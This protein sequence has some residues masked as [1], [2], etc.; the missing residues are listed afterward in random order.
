[1]VVVAVRQIVVVLHANDLASL[2]SIRDLRRRR[3]A[4]SNVTR[5]PLALQIG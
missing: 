2:A 5:Q 1:L 3:V 4:Q